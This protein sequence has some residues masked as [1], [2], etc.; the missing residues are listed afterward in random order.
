M[1]DRIGA[2]LLMLLVSAS[3]VIAQGPVSG[4][5][6]D[7]LSRQV[8]TLRRQVDSLQKRTDSLSRELKT[9]MAEH[10]REHD[11]A[12][13]L[14]RGKSVRE[15]ADERALETRL[16]AIESKL[17]G[18]MRDDPPSKPSSA[19]SVV[20]A[21]FV[22]QDEKGVVI[23]RMTGGKSPRLIV[24]DNDA[25]HVELGTGNAGGGIVAVR[26]ASKTLR[27]QMLASDGFGQFRA[28][29]AQHSA[30]LTASD[31]GA[32]VSLFFG[33][34]PSARM[35][36]GKSGFGALVLTDPGGIEMVGAGTIGEVGIVSAGP[37][38]RPS[39]LATSSVI[40]GVK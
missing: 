16:A 37:R 26:D 40:K 5:Q 11:D 27:A 22:V 2:A 18:V 13:A 30:V 36:A 24:G 29:S 35:R 19:A 15:K 20:R 39:G 14:E 3:S 33:D 10:K 9:Y 23:L 38:Q 8:T 31:E 7:A 1:S 32:V 21:P 6:L 25:G 12:D 28:S 34:T 4:G 17:A